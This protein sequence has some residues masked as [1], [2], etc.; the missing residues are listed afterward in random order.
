MIV[1]TLDNTII[2]MPLPSISPTKSTTLQPEPLTP[3]A[4]AEF[5]TVIASPLARDLT[6]Y[7]N[8]IPEPAHTGHQPK[9]VPANQ[10]TA[11]KTSP[12]SPLIN[13]YASAEKAGTGLMSIFSSFPRQNVYSAPE[14]STTNSGLRLKLGILERHPYTT[15]TFCPF[16]YSSSIDGSDGKTYMLIVVAPTTKSSSSDPTN[17]PDLSRVRAFVAPLNDPE[18]PNMAVTYG[19]GTW[20]AP[21]IVLGSRRVDFLVSQF[22]NGIAN[23]DV[24]EVLI[25]SG[26]DESKLTESM[27]KE[28]RESGLP[29]Q[30]VEIDVSFV[31]DGWTRSQQNHELQKAMEQRWTTDEA[32]NRAIQGT[33]DA[34]L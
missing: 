17:P 28:R 27:L 5:G 23:D 25:G 31:R 10:L 3:A 9:S 26:P 20:H 15:Q 8:D 11:L 4:F 33:R 34:K 14:S 29:A 1:E 13:N 18:I 16:G 2:K 24:Q 30:S 32:V 19:A 21:M 22:A 6:A 12:I 7:P